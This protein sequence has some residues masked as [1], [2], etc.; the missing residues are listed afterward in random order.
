MGE[1]V[2]SFGR[3]RPWAF[4]L[5]ASCVLLMCASRLPVS[6]GQGLPVPTAVGESG[7]GAGSLQAD[8]P[9]LVSLLLWL[10]ALHRWLWWGCAACSSVAARLA[11]VTVSRSRPVVRALVLLLM[12]LLFK[13]IVKIFDLLILVQMHGW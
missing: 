3:G 5:V 10:S 7:G 4:L 13:T 8:V 2:A 12:L 1:M 11:A 9:F 6:Q